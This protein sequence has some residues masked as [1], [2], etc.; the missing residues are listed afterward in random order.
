M[1]NRN[2]AAAESHDLSALNLTA[3]NF[4]SFY[5][6]IIALRFPIEVAQVL[7]L[8]FVINH[9]VDAFVEPPLTPD[10]RHFR[11]ALLAAID[12]FGIDNKR[13]SERLLRIMTMLRE[14]H[15]DH[16]LESRDSE[17]ELRAQMDANR[18]ARAQSSRY[19]LFF[20]ILTVLLGIPWMAMT[21]PTWLVK[22]PT[23]VCAYLAWDYFHTS[24]I[25]DRQMAVLR[26]QLNDV[27]RQ[28]VRSV[29]WKTL[30]HKLAL[31]LGY[32]HIQGVEVFH[33]SYDVDHAGAPPTH[34]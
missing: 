16:S 21:E 13:H 12:S 11:N 24:P 17:M 15:Y 6:R 30:I 7:E 18:R 23:A 27:L 22:V 32:K 4:H 28:R 31:I 2:M 20:V 8:R 29:N 5:H 25:L 34:H 10:Y 9:A 33:M 26:Q 1:A 19:G 14:L 3:E